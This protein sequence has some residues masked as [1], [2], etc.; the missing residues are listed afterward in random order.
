MLINIIITI[1]YLILY[2]QSFKIIL[3]NVVV[4]YHS[5]TAE[6]TVILSSK[7]TGGS[8]LNS[9]LAIIVRGGGGRQ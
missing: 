3:W 4:V 8:I 9:F 6:G 1:L 7:D 5:L 2:K